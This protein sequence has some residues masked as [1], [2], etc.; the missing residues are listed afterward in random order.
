MSARRMQATLVCHQSE[1]IRKSQFFGRPCSSRHQ[2]GL[3]CCRLVIIASVTVVL[4]VATIQ[5]VKL[6]IACSGCAVR[7]YRS[8]DL[9]LS[10]TLRLLN[11]LELSSIRCD[12]RP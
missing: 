7:V 8:L 3:S 11:P 1:A 12:S 2:V 6:N 4:T 10:P 5:A 9:H